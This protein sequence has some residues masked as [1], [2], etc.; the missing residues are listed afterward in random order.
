METEILPTSKGRVST[1][2]PPTV[3]SFLGDQED[4]F[5]EI[6]DFIHLDDPKA[7]NIGLLQGPAGT[8]KTYLV[9]VLIQTLKD[10]NFKN[11]GVLAP[12]GQAVKIC[13]E[14]AVEQSDTIRYGTVHSAFAVRPKKESEIPIF[15]VDK[16]G[17]QWARDCS[18]LFVDEVSQ[19]ADDLF[20]L[21]EDY[22]TQL[23]KKV[24]LIG[25]SYQIP[26]IG[27]E[28]SIPFTKAEQKEYDIKVFELKKPIRQKEGSPI[29]DNADLIRKY[30]KYPEIY[31]PE[32][33]KNRFNSKREGIEFIKDKGSHK[34]LLKKW[35]LHPEYQNNRYFVK[36]LAWR[37]DTVDNW[38]TQV[39]KVLYGDNPD[40]IEDTRSKSI[41][42]LVKGEKLISN[43]PVIEKNDFG[44]DA[45][46]FGSN[47]DLMLVSYIEDTYKVDEAGK[48]I[49]G[50]YDAIVEYLDQDGIVCT[51]TIK[52]LKNE[53]KKLHQKIQDKLAKIAKAEPKGSNGARAGWADFWEFDAIFADVNYNYCQ[54][55]HKSQGSTYLN[56][57]VLEWDIL[58]GRKVFERNRILYVGASRAK[59]NLIQIY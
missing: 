24:I 59:Q 48:F 53:S 15:E 29:L 34:E 19:I 14:N 46:V 4:K 58:L 13:R 9:G 52:I 25:D 30:I 1:K 27:F 42:Q 8:G 11:I 36:V 7:G 57:I 32:D 16:N 41:K 12:T 51:Y 17:T 40:N 39:R 31:L 38:N 23:D 44:D 49:L 50:Y 43:S 21:L 54:T 3:L 2:K 37:N 5:K 22:A 26:P 55:C 47:E 28:Y 56:S 6:L 45:V 10:Q 20:F 18:I 33:R 35:F